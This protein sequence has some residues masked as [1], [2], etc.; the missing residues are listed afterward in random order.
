MTS[1]VDPVRRR[2]A[3]L[4]DQERVQLVRAHRQLRKAIAGYERF[5][6]GP[7]APGEQVPVH[8]AHQMADAQ[9]AVEAAEAELWRLREEL[10]GWRRPAWAPRATLVADWFSDEDSV[11]DASTDA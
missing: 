5:I 9:A 3:E 4:T 6:G 8:D 7:L 11:Y 1:A 2:E 10:L